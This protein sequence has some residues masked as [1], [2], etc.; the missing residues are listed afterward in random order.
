MESIRQKK[1]GLLAKVL[2]RLEEENIEY[3][4]LGGVEPN[5]KDDL[6]YQGIEIC[7]KEQVNFILAIGGVSVI[8]SVKGIAAG[9]KYQGDFWDFFYR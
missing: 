9:V 7:R 3:I 6:V 1:S 8:D 4:T 5:L 2:E